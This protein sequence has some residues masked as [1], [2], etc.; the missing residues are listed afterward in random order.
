[1]KI[2]FKKLWDVI[3][4]KLVEFIITL[5]ILLSIFV[6]KNYLSVEINIYIWYIIIIFIIFVISTYFN[7]KYFIKSKN[8]AFVLYKIKI[9][10]DENE[11]YRHSDDKKIYF[12]DYKDFFYKPF[13]VYSGS[14]YSDSRSLNYVFGPYCEKCNHILDNGEKYYKH[15]Y[16]IN[17]DKNYNIPKE[18][19]HSNYWVRLNQYF[20]FK[21]NKGEI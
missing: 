12:K 15:F 1:M 5:I 20:L 18:L 9:I 10:K 21:F 13:I 6:F 16:C 7:I 14:R 2:F 8:K 19:K 3:T 11:G 4:N 17:C